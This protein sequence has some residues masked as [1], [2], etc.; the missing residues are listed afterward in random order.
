[1]HWC[2]TGL[3]SNPPVLRLPVDNSYYFALIPLVSD[4]DITSPQEYLS[5]G[6]IYNK[7]KYENGELSI[8]LQTN[9]QN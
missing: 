4:E 8:I 3:R 6:T 5:F 2:V 1:M 7:R 9:A